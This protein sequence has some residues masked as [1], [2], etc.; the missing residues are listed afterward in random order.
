MSDPRPRTAITVPLTTEERNFLLHR[1]GCVSQVIDTILDR[2]IQP[3]GKLKPQW[4]RQ[5]LQRAA[6]QLI[7]ALRQYPSIL[8][9]GDLQKALIVEAIEGNKYFVLP[10]GDPRLSTFAIRKAEALRF[11]LSNA[12]HRPIR[13]FSIGLQD[14][15]DAKIPAAGDSADQDRTGSSDRQV[16]ESAGCGDDAHSSAPTR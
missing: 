1:L 10:N 9:V 2:P 8:I 3:G 5:N 16:Q 15:F 14:S 13:Q 6:W 12:L 4:E 7:D 11:K